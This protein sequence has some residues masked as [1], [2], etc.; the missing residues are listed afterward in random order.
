MGDAEAA[1]PEYFRA[2]HDAQIRGRWLDDASTPPVLR[3]RVK[4][5][6][7]LVDRGRR[8]WFERLLQPHVDAFGRDSLAAR[9]Q[10]HCRSTSARRLRNG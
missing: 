3:E 2:V 10:R 4:R 1:L 7:Q 6:M 8:E 9:G 5:A